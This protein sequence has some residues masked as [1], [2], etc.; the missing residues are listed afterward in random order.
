MPALESLTYRAINHNIDKL[1][2]FEPVIV[3]LNRGVAFQRLQHLS[4]C[5]HEHPIC[6]SPYEIEDAGW[7][8]VLNALG[9]AACSLHLKS[10]DLIY[11]SL[12]PA[13]M[14]TF[15]NLLAQNSFPKLQVLKLYGSF[16]IKDEGIE[17]LVQGLLAPAC[18]TR[19]TT[20]SLWSVGMGDKGVIALSSL[21]PAGRFEQLE[22]MSLECNS[23]VTEQGVCVL[24][25]AVQDIRKRG[26]SRLPRSFSPLIALR[27]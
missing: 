14:A 21:F 13:S 2:D 19:L 25:Q 18:Q 4:L 27:H 6:R 11:S 5:T 1:T 8:R 3:D 10:F 24:E 15:S 22:M 23:D 7:D 26:L 9:G 12:S 17:Y 16:G 20:L